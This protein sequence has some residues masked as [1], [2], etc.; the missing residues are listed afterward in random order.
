MYLLHLLHKSLNKLTSIVMYLVFHAVFIVL[1]F[2]CKLN[3]GRKS[4]SFSCMS[5]PAAPV[6]YIHTYS[7]RS[8]PGSRIC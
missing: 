4:Y 6:L 3:G 8:V 1:T 7:S 2:K 5:V